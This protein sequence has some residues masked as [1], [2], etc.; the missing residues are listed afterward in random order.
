MLLEG[1]VETEDYPKPSPAVQQRPGLRSRD[2]GEHYSLNLVWD[3][4]SGRQGTSA[5]K[6]R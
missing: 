1:L 3:A 6:Q 4:L 2:S 5:A